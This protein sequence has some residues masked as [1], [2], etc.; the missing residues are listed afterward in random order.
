[1]KMIEQSGTYY[2]LL[3]KKE[4]MSVYL[5]KNKFGKNRIFFLSCEDFSCR[6]L[7]YISGFFKKRL[8]TYFK[9]RFGHIKSYNQN[10]LLKENY[11]C[12]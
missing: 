4:S 1:M 8:Y 12:Y 7:K 5:I 11:I 2:E 3:N 6:L 10:M 9:E